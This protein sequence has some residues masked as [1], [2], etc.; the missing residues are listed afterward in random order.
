ML[1]PYLTGFLLGLSLILAIGSQNA[2]VL[3]QGI[4]R[5]HVGY[6]VF[7]CTFADALLIIV[8][9][10]GASYFIFDFVNDFKRWLFGGAAVWLCGYG[11]LRIR[12]VMG[13]N[14]LREHD[15]SS[16][17]LATTLT[18]VALLTFG[19][20]HVYLDTVILIGAVSL[21]YNGIEKLAFAGGAISAS[22]VFFASLGYGGYLVSGLMRRPKVWR[23]L[24]AV[25]AL[26][27]FSIAAAMLRAG[28]WY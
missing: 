16:G 5:Q 20:P 3:R 12:D 24:N 14:F 17:G 22:F 15:V 28:N 4:L 9:V 6:I 10:T 19:N 8:G 18:T 25:I 11:L 2:F 27:M 23:V 7:F 26:I 21:K 13:N 1:L